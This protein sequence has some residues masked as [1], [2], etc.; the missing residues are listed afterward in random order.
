VYFHTVIRLLQWSTR[1]QPEVGLLSRC[2]SGDRMEESMDRACDI[3]GEED[4]W[5]WFWWG[6]L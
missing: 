4:K 6:N 2:Y 3:R 5:T 1:W